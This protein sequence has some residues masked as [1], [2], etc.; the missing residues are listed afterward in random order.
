MSIDNP[1]THDTTVRRS[2]AGPLGQFAA[3]H[4]S[5]TS[6]IAPSG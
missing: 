1:G 2:S 4:P 5:D 6:G 3:T